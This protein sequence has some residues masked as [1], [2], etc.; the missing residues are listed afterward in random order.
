MT[1]QRKGQEGGCDV[2]FVKHWKIIIISEDFCMSNK[3]NAT[4]MISVFKHSLIIGGTITFVL[5]VMEVELLFVILKL[6]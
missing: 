4:E 2:V 5:S 6:P 1:T 3:S